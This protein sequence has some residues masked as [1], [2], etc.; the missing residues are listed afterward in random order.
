M[1]PPSPGGPT[2]SVPQVVFPPASMTHAALVAE[3]RRAYAP[4]LQ[5]LPGDTGYQLGFADPARTA[6][7][8]GGILA[9]EDH[10]MHLPAPEITRRRGLAARNRQAREAFDAYAPLAAKQ[11]MAAAHVTPDE[12]GAVVVASSTVTAM[13]SLA[14]ALA[15]AAG[16]S[17]RAEAISLGSEGCNGGAAAILQARAH[18]LAH[19]CP[20]L[21]V[22]ADYASPWFH[23]E[24]GL[25]GAIVSSVLFSDA[26]GAAVMTPGPRA[27][28]GF[29]I[30]RT[31]SA[32]LPGTEDAL[33]W[34]VRDDG[35]HFRLTG[36]PKVVPGILPA[37]RDLL[38]ATG[39]QAGDLDACT[40][41]SGGN[42]IIRAVQQGLGLTRD[43][44]APAWG[45][46]R[47]G[48]LMSAA[49]LHAMAIAAA[50][51]GRPARHG[52]RG[53]LAG[54]GPGF[55]MSAAAWQYHA[56]APALAAVSAA[57]AG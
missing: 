39:W 41:H 24:P 6:L 38:D 52:G 27:V 44:V 2:L 18:V 47:R 11:A 1:S 5:H 28:P 46:L 3:V 51:P 16:L 42:A 32:R 15:S 14:H 23:L 45:S 53:I 26:A 56:P 10:P 33:G 57:A 55:A 31:T 29:R 9:I 19:G 40:I 17:D 30:L 25:R 49:V 34:D 37:L 4:L 50:D 20:V 12:I 22:A 21:V 48:D 35:Y 13:P 7:K 36:P 8:M 43:Q 54:F